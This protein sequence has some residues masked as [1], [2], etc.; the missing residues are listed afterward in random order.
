MSPVSLSGCQEE[1]LVLFISRTSWMHGRKWRKT[2]KHTDPLW[3][4][5]SQ[6]SIYP[7]YMKEKCLVKINNGENLK[8]R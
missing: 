6:Q 5:T 8:L 7:D 1:Q 2:V 4:F 3:Y